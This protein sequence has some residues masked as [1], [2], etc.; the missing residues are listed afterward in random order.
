M[1]GRKLVIDGD[2]QF[3]VLPAPRLSVRDARLANI[4]GASTPDMVRLKSLE[5][6]I[7][8][9][10]L[11]QGRIEVESVTLVEP[12]IE[13]EILADGRANWQFA[14]PRRGRRESGLASGG[15]APARAPGRSI[16]K[17]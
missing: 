7:R 16:Q 2:L 6:R 11:L 15:R 3:S 9:L 1:I 13:L 10:P 5:V 4:E 14:A 8:F 12:V 17:K